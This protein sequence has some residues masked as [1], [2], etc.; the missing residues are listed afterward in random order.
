MHHLPWLLEQL[1]FVGDAWK[2]EQSLWHQGDR[3]EGDELVPMEHSLGAHTCADSAYRP[4]PTRPHW[5]P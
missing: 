4:P 1:L 3:P 5:L 2:R